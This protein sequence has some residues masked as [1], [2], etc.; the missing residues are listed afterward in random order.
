VLPRAATVA[1]LCLD[2]R[3]EDIDD[4]NAWQHWERIAA[5]AACRTESLIILIAVVGVSL[6][7]GLFV[8]W[9]RDVSQ[10]ELLFVMD[11]R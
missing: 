2:G 3:D 11:D 8:V 10:E 6:G 5:M 9:N 7:W 1:R 4:V